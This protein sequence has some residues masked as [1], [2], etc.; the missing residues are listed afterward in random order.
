MGEMEDVAALEVTA[1]TCP[2]AVLEETSFFLVQQRPNL[3][4]RPN[5]V[6]TFFSFG[7]GI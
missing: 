1:F 6:Q 7:V 2:I 4:N 3:G 5:V